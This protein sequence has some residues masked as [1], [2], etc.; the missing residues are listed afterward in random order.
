MF[1]WYCTIRPIINIKWLPICSE[2]EIAFPQ[3]YKNFAV[4]CSLKIDVADIVVFL[5]PSLSL[6][7]NKIGVYTL[8]L[9]Q[10][11]LHHFHFLGL[12]ALHALIFCLPVIKGG[13]A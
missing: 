11:R 7:P 1:F 4:P 13:L 10:F 3:Y 9:G 6:V 12:A 2:G 8:E 5:E